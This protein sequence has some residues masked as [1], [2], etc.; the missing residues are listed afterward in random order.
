MADLFDSDV[1][2]EYLRG[3]TGA[4]AFVEARIEDACISA[5][6]VG[7]I[8]QGVRAHE[9]EQVALTLSAFRVLPVTMEIARIGGLFS[10]DHRRSHGCGLADCLIAAT[11]KAHGLTLQ[12][13]NRKHFP[14][15]EDV[16]VPY[17]RP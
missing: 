5:V 10:R 2:I 13:F 9:E 16:N 3:E 8:Y 7:E 17:V 11:A 4:V 12:T 14:M 15:I 6:T 1:L